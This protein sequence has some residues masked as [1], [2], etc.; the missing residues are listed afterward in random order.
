MRE[1]RFED[2]VNLAGILHIILCG[3]WLALGTGCEPRETGEV[4]QAGPSMS[5]EQLLALKNAPVRLLLVGTEE[6]AEELRLQFEGRSESKLETTVV[7]QEKWDSLTDDSL[8]SYDVIVAPTDRLPTWALDNRLLAFPDQT[9]DNWGYRSWL[10]VDRRLGR[11]QQK[12]FGVSLGTPVWG[13]VYNTAAWAEEQDASPSAVTPLD[14]ESIQTEGGEELAASGNQPDS[15]EANLLPRTWTEWRERVERDRANGVGLRW[16]EPMAELGAAKA[17]L[18]RAA[19][20]SMN[21]SQTDVLFA[22]GDGFPRVNSPPF[23]RAILDLCETYGDEIETLRS[24]TDA[25]AIERVRRGEAIAA[26]VRLPRL[27][28]VNSGANPLRVAP[29]PGARRW[30][31]FFDQTWSMRPG[32]QI[33]RVQLAGLDS[34]AVFVMRRT[35]KSEAAF[36]LTELLVTSPTAAEMANWRPN[37]SLYRREQLDELPQ[38][39]G[40]QHISDSL[41][42]I[43]ETYELA[44]DDVQGGTA[45]FWP[46]PGNP[47][48]L[49]ALEAAVESFAKAPAS[50]QLEACS[51]TWQEITEQNGQDQLSAILNGLR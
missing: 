9:L 29:L 46:L 8:D 17:V 23:E 49:R 14:A 15:S 47:L 37:I 34:L 40:R 19:S 25:E 27:N 22:R 7:D 12:T 36:R 2:R 35:R 44:N 51:E 26:I 13:I 33:T 50:G 4:Q 38:W 30:Y 11:F 5:E 6:W 18:L 16:L 42:V 31:N 45:W 41:T 39:A 1:H 21:A 28:D 24:L 48:R 10:P 43:R 3:L 20:M 32:K